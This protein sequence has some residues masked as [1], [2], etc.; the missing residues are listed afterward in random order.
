M[1]KKPYVREV[2][3]NKKVTRTYGN[4]EELAILRKAVKALSDGNP[5][6]QEF[7]DYHNNVE[8]IKSES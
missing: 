3:I 2:V 6:S 8:Q 7:I 4:G 5:V 1:E